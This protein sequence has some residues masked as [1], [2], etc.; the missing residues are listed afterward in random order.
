MS[1][2]SLLNIYVMMTMTYFGCTL[3]GSTRDIHSKHKNKFLM[4][5]YKK[6]K[7]A[8]KDVTVKSTSKVVSSKDFKDILKVISQE[9]PKSI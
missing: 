3:D 5:S 4:F 7:I 8:F 2:N 9:D 6:K 1:H